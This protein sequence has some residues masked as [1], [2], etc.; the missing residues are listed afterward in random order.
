MGDLLSEHSAQLLVLGRVCLA[1]LLGAAVGV[2]RELA[3]KPAGLRTHMLVAGSAALLIGLGDFLVD[4]FGDPAQ[5]DLLRLDP[6]R[7]ME[8]LVTGIAFLGAGTI[9]R[10][11]N[12][13]DSVRGLTTAASILFT[14]IVGVAVAMSQYLLAV[15]ATALVLLTLRLV[16]LI[17]KRL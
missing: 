16:A 15:G 17:G 5:T 13:P 10:D 7:L 11:R 14:A 3:D 12:D 4:H 8:A 9:I 6:I 1:V 2:E